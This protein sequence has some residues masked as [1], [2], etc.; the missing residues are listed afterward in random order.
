MRILI[1][2][3]ADPR[4]DR[5]GKFSPAAIVAVCGNFCSASE[6]SVIFVAIFM[7]V[8][9]LATAVPS[10]E[11]AGFVAYKLDLGVSWW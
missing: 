7:V 3:V 11:G 1:V 9:C 6:K 5:V 10:M 8:S 4:D 2:A